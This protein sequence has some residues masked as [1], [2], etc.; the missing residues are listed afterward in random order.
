MRRSLL[1][2]VLVAGAVVVLDRWTKTWAASSLPF[3]Q[4]VPLL[5]Q[6]LRFTYTRN[7]GVAFG[8]GQGTRFPYYV[9]S[10]AATVAIV[11]MFLRR[12]VHTLARQLALALILG[13]ALG[14]LW[15]R[16]ARGEV[17]D[18]IEVGVRR[19]Y[20]PV[21]NVADSAVTVGVILF[22]LAWPRRD[23]PSADPIE[24]SASGVPGD[25][26]HAGPPGPG[27]ES[28]GAAGPLPRESPDRPL[29]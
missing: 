5:G 22:A 27:L 18:F 12:Q 3:N 25:V 21:F 19:W 4:P 23:T 13:G 20:W 11:A 9:F 10:I 28:R 15:D 6:Y 29:A 2:L 26:A 16:L 24:A 17:T 8:L 7:S 1:L 14:N